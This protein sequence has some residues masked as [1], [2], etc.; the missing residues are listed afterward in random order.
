MILDYTYNRK[1]R[2]FSIS[3]VNEIGGK[4]L[5]KFNV[6]RF[7]TY[8]PSE[9]GKYTNWDGTK[10]DVG[11]TEK[12]TLFEF[13]TFIEELPEDKKKL[14][15]GK[16]SPKLFTF[17]IETAIPEDNSEFPDP[18]Y[19]KFPITTISVVSSEMNA[20]VLGVR[21]MSQSGQDRLQKW[22]TEWLNNCDFFKSLGLPMPYVKYVEFNSEEDMIRYFLKNIVS[23]VA[24]IAGWNSLGFDWQYFQTRIREY[25]P[26]LS[27]NLSSMTYSTSPKNIMDMKGEKTRLW[28]PDHTLVLDMMEII[29]DFDM[30][31][32]P[33]K[34]SMALDY[35][36]SES[37]GM[38][39]I[40]YTGNLQDLYNNDYDKYVFY[41]VIDSVLVQLIDK[42][43]KTLINICTQALYCKER[44][45]ACFSK[46]AVSES[47]VFN[48]FYEHGIKITY[49][50]EK[51]EITRGDLKGAYVK[52]PMPGKHNFVCCNDFASLYPTGIITCNISYENFMGNDYTPE[53]IEKFKADPNYFVS[54]NG[55]VYKNDKDYSFKR[56]QKKL[57][58]NRNTGK[59]LA[60]QLDAI[61]MTDIDHILK[62]RDKYNQ[63]ILKEG[64][65]HK[66]AENLVKAMQEIG[67]EIFN[68]MDI[69]NHTNDWIK[70]FKQKLANEI[71][72]YV[73]F[74]QAMKLLGNSMY[75]GS[76]H[77]AFK[78][79]NIALANDITGEGRNLIHMME[80]H[81]PEFWK[82]NW[83]TLT[84]VHKMLGIKISLEKCAE[85]LKY[86]KT[87]VDMVY[88]DTDSLYISYEK[89][90]NT[91]I[92][93]EK[94]SIAE[95]RDIIVRLNTEF[96]DKHNG[97]YMDAY[98][99][100]RHAISAHKFELETLSLSGVWL[101]VKKRYA[102]ILLWKDGKIF[103][104]DSLP[105]KVKGLEIIKSSYPSQARDCLKRMVRLLLES[106]NKLLLQKLNVAMQK[107][108]QEFY[109]APIENICFNAGV[110]PGKYTTYILDD[111]SPVLDVAKKCPVGPK[112]LGYYNGFR[113]AYKL[114][115]EPLY[116]GKIKLYF[117]YPVEP[118]SKV[119]LTREAQPFG[120]QPSS[121]PEWAETYAPV[122]KEILFEKSV[123]NPFNRI[124][125]NIGIGQ[126]EID[127]NIHLS[128]FD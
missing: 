76:S 34:E 86:D 56:I 119:R 31:V 106:D 23:K 82:D 26:N 92:G 59:Y 7:K 108:K 44:I 2:V 50:D 15:M 112:A 8:Y 85:T 32:M 55:N 53:E 78:W 121:Y 11:Y 74:E 39:K 38:H 1:Q 5:M 46:I 45:E 19:A 117:F 120:F 125:S 87:F 16:V 107:E 66:Y 97:E 79:F 65:A 68:A 126:L 114:P 98:Y 103:D 104:L 43:F 47:L 63:M 3:Y 58:E 6:N 71:T 116:G 61:V 37:I 52:Q 30:A 28:C 42:K 110:G 128:L 24:A 48:D 80:K 99:K 118:N 115:G 75:G 49:S 40:K 70:T 21:G 69:L 57:K 67:Y 94:M 51:S 27:L 64:S 62:N 12:P 54:V 33:I 36:A 13:K 90:L 77:V 35:I 96:M 89:L 91:I 4:G 9:N 41:N 14:L 113:N 22:Y 81:I 84:D 25:Y 10:C 17:D 111:S 73:S 105:L 29:K 60:K 109:K 100:S 18:M 95:K 72:F 101:D 123:L 102:Q 83:T 127:G 88:G 20:I 93:V 122:C 124:I